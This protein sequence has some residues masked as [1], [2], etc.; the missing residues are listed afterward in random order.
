MLDN[1]TLTKHYFSALTEEEK[2]AFLR[3]FNLTGKNKP[4]PK[5]K[6]ELPYRYSEEYF[7]NNYLIFKFSN[8]E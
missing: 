7:Y 5:I 1:L 2:C 8:K 4:K 3:E 6:K